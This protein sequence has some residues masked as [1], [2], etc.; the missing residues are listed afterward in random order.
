V[1]L[2]NW[3]PKT[4]CTGQTGYQR[5]HAETDW[6]PKITCRNRLET[7]DNMH[8]TDY[9]SKKTS[10]YI[11]EAKDNIQ[12]QTGGQRQHAETDWRLKT[13]CRDRLEN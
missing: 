2:T 3:R 6:R 1:Q 13:T 5:K 4:T 10:R 12:I 9:R 7:K 8:R 11:L